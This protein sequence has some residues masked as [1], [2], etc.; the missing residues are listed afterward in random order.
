[1][2]DQLP[3]NTPARVSRLLTAA[4][5]HRLSDVPPEVEWFRNLTNPST[6]R[7]YETAVKDFMRFT[8]IRRPRNSDRHARAYH[9]LARRAGAARP[10][11]QH[12]PAPARVAGVAV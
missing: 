1:M 3:A 8:G 2:T 10:R 6:R 12:D 7:A 4:E 11:R 5:F 9:R